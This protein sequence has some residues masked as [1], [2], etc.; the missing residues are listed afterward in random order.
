MT[1][2]EIRRDTA[3]NVYIAQADASLKALGFSS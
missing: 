1:Y 3:V 2:E